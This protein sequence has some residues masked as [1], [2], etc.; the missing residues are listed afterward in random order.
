MEKDKFIKTYLGNKD[1]SLKPHK[2]FT[3]DQLDKATGLSNARYQVYA[4]DTLN[5]FI[6]AE[7]PA[8]ANNRIK[9]TRFKLMTLEINEIC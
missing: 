5:D 9:T 8:G 2:W 3:S 4:S 1:G 6:K 7:P